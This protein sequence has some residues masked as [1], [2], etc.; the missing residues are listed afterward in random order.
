MNK[1]KLYNV[2]VLGA[3]GAVGQEMIKVL[4]ER[5]FP[6]GELHLLA[7]ARSAGKT[8]RFGARELVI[9]EACDAAFAGMDIVLGAAENDIAKRFAPAI[10]AAGAMFV[11]N[12]SA[13]RLDPDV[14]LV[15]PEINPEDVAAAKK[16]IIAN[17]NCSTIITL[18]ALA[19]IA[20]ISPI[21]TLVASTYQAVSGAGAE[22]LAELEA[23]AEAYPKGEPLQAK[24]FPHQILFNLIPRIGGVG[25]NGYSSEEMKLQNEGRKILHLPELR[26]TCTCV[27]VPVMRSH[28]ISATFTTARPVSVEEARTALASAPGVQLVD[29]P[30]NDVYPMPLA[31]SDQDDVFV[32]RI[33]R[34]LVSENGLTL[35]C[36]G[37][38]IRKG[39]ATN[40]IQ[41]AELLIQ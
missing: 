27:R 11:D 12:S 21:Q 3:T 6:I 23:Q 8:V 24:A 10:Q 5:N 33:R 31:T 1:K 35:W 14:P 20:R 15:V 16:G 38:Q 29:D 36:C 25:E 32:G 39:A 22:G 26:V 30:N 19:P 18:M 13:F 40:A 37:D 2:A 41:I 34:D 28:S 17:P 9:E 7:S 4:A